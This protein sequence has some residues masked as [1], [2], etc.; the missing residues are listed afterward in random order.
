M[1]IFGLCNVLIIVTTIIIIVT[2]IIIINNFTIAM[3]SHQDGSTS[4]MATTMS[5]ANVFTIAT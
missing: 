2:T 1:H 3:P 5:G 4:S